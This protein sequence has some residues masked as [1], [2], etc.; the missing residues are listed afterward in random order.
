[1]TKETR[2][3][4]LAALLGNA[5][6][7][8]SFMFS[9]IALGIAQPF[10]MLMYRFIG[11]FLGL[12]LLA[13]WSVIRR[14]NGNDGGEKIDAMRFSLKGKP[15]LPLLALGVVQPVVYFLCESYGISLTN[16]TFSG[17]IISL[18]PI[19][20]L[21][22]GAVFLNEKPA[23]AQVLYSLLSIAGVVLMTMMQS[24]EGEI[25]PLGVILLCGA[26]L[27]GVVFNIISRSIS[28][29]FSALERTYVMMFIAAVFFTVL[30]VVTTGADIQALLA[31]AASGRF[32]LAIGY[33]SIISSI[34]AFMMLN[35]ANNYLPVAKT[36]A[37]CNLTTVISLFAGVI[38]LG[39]PFGV[40]SLIASVM[41]VL[42]VWGVQKAEQKS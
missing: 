8:F 38:F 17:V 9:R 20:G 19:V 34:V 40:V 24:A 29:Q 31:P 37:F 15:L 22:L 6:F 3:A 36:T 35:Y 18:V 25:H 42:G 33:L 2:L 10:V 13:L 32:M 23:R 16:A 41:I 21:A 5:I 28:S 11:A 1:M 12:N 39:E 7:G 27:S 4:T 14:K 30:A 26:V